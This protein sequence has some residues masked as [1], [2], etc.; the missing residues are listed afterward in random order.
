MKG[1]GAPDEQLRMYREIA[2][3]HVVICLEG[4]VKLLQRLAVFFVIAKRDEKGKKM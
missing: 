2:E 1:L 4:A 3:T